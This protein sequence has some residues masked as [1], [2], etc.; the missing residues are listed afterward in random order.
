MRVSMFTFCALLSLP[1][2]AADAAYSLVERWQV[3][4]GRGQE[5]ATYLTAG[6]PD[7]T[8]YLAD[9]YGRVAVIDAKGK[10]RS[11]QIRPEYASA[12]ALACDA[13]SRLFIANSREIVIIKK[14]TIVSRMPVTVNITAMAPAAGGSIY[15]AGRAR[16]NTLPLHLIDSEGAVVKSFG[17]QSADPFNR[18]YPRSNSSLVWQETLG[19]LLYI[20]KTEGFA[21]QA[22]RADGESIGV[23]GKQAPHILPVRVAENSEPALGQAVGAAALPHNQIA[24]QR[25][26]TQWSWRGFASRVLEIY[27][28]RLRRIGV[29]PSDVRNLAGSTPDGDLFFATISPR[30]L[31]VFKVG[32]IKRLSL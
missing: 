19:R 31:Q 20:P 9:S 26:V 29:A 14:G 11:R 13:D 17:I 23:F 6:C 25:E 1:L 12:S 4:F 7:G 3:N 21:I 5:R 24:I 27:D 18:F 10:V 32:L 8:F 22:Y 15:A 28:A 30:G 2:S 16:A